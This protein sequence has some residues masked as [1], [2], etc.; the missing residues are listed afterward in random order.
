MLTIAHGN[1]TLASRKFFIDQ[2]NEDSLT[3]DAEDLIISEL[4]Q[5]L[6]GGG[7]FG[8]SKKIFIENLFTRKGLK[9]I[10]PIA[11]VLSQ[12]EKS[13]EIYIWSEKEL[14]IKVLSPF[15][16]H[17]NQ[18]FKIPSNIFSF[19]DSIRPNNPKNVSYFHDAIKTSE[20]EIV[21]FMIIRQFRLLLGIVS[22]SKNN[23]D[24]VKRLA[25]WQKSKLIKQSEIF[26]EEKLKQIYKKI[27]KIDKS[28]KTGGTNLTL[29]QNI[30]ILL[31]DL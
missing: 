20:P 12:N 31:L 13:S 17:D 3:F 16:K 26:G 24:E 8:P 2:K 11:S 10:E 14:G 30:D 18:N 6:Q 1:N 25:P 15:P 23:I 29:I 28:Q 9:N 19:L 4:K 27:Y 22:N 5:S 21:F 7:L